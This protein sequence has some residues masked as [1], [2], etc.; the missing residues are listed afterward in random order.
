MTKKFF[1]VNVLIEPIPNRTPYSEAHPMRI[2]E[3]WNPGA[4]I[5]IFMVIFL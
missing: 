5:R 4:S 3:K 1:T 2:I